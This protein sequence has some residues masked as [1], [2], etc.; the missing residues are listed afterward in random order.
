MAAKMRIRDI[1][2]WGDSGWAWQQRT[3]FDEE[4]QDFR[5]NGE[6]DGLWA[7]KENG[8]DWNQIEGTCQYWLPANESAA[9][10]RIRRFWI[11]TRI[12]W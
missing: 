5:T 7:L 8:Y 11:K 1:E 3:A 2:A 9:R 12:D 10:G 4:W 6:G